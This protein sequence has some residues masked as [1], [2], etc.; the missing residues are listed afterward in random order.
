MSSDI[1]YYDELETRSPDQREKAL[2][3]ALPKF[4]LDAKK[5]SSYFGQ[6]LKNVNATDIKN[7]EALASLPVT[8]KS[9][10][11]RLQKE[12]LPFGGLTSCKPGELK[13]IYQSP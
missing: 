2:F 1:L 3:G 13:R 6:I 11:I 9:D 8:R 7:R 12:N 5:K 10:L 4:I